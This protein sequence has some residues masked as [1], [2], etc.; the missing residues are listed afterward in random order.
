MD[1]VK[2]I[3]DFYISSKGNYCS[4]T[5]TAISGYGDFRFN[6]FGK[7]MQKKGSP[8]L[9]LEPQLNYLISNPA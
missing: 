7:N 8:L 5:Q 6:Y 2:W 9:T 3:L 1:G 4:E